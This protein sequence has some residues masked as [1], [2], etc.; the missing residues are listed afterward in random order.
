MHCQEWG[1]LLNKPVFGCPHFGHMAVGSFPCLHEYKVE[2]CKKGFHILGG[3]DLKALVGSK[4]PGKTYCHCSQP[5]SCQF[6]LPSRYILSD[7]VCHRAWWIR[8]SVEPHK[9]RCLP[10]PRHY[11]ASRSDLPLFPDRQIWQT[12]T[13]PEVLNH[14]WP[15]KGL[16]VDRVHVEK[17]GG[18]C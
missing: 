3:A 17:D 6:R 16:W 18:I 8:V 12:R 10:G 5:S 1:S 13:A 7:P 14:A 11:W 15:E 9:A 2:E 4:V